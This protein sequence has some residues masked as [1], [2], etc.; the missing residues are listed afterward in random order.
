MIKD[1]CWRQAASNINHAEVADS[2]CFAVGH[3]NPLCAAA[4]ALRMTNTAHC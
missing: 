2:V 4:H 3:E 1:Y